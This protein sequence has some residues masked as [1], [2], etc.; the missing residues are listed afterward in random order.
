[1]DCVLFLVGVCLAGSSDSDQVDQT[2]ANIYTNGEEAKIH[3]SHSISSYNQILWY[4]QSEKQLLLLG[5]MYY[6]KSNPEPGVNVT[7]DGDARQH[8]NCTLTIKYLKV[9]SSGVY[10]CAARYHSAAHHCTSIQKPPKHILKVSVCVTSCFKKKPTIPKL[11]AV[12]H[13]NIVK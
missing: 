11:S 1:M 13:L 9:S 12:S 4:K 8:K 6:D 2:P 10:F 7:M 5:Y 3:C